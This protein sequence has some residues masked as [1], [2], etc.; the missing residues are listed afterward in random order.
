MKKSMVQACVHKN[1]RREINSD[2]HLPLIKRLCFVETCQYIQQ[3]KVDPLSD[4]RSMLNELITC[5][6][7]FPPQLRWLII[8]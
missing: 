7:V 3:F 8:L 5:D 1:V 4:F 2:S 6:V